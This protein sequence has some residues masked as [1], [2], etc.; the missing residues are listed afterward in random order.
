MHKP[1][2]IFRIAAPLFV[3]VILLSSAACT[4]SSPARSPAA[5]LSTAE[6]AAV[7]APV[8]GAEY[9]SL[10]VSAVGKATGIPDLTTLSLGVS[11]TDESVAEARRAAAQSMA[12]VIATLKEQGV[13]DADITTS[14]FRIHEEY[15]YSRQPRRKVGYTVSNG[16]TVTVRQTDTVAGIIDA[17]VA[18]GGDHI[19][20]NNIGFSFSD[21]AAMEREARQAAVAAMQEKATQLA[22][23]AGRDLGSLKALSEGVFDGGAPSGDVLLAARAE[24]A[25][26]DTPIAVGEDDVVVVVHGVYELK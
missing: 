12:S 5:G 10:Q 17:A 23:F 7:P 4:A 18:A 1:G 20:F 9:D 3:V 6:A 24:A 11:V 8:A 21:T 14:H 26:Y 19:E 22:G 25:S 13:L 15:D 2:R 16:V